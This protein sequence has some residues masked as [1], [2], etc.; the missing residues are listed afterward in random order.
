MNKK[1]MTAILVTTLVMLVGTSTLFAKGAKELAPESYLGQIES[2]EVMEGGFNYELLVKNADGNTVLFRTDDQTVA[3]LPLASL[4]KGDYV[5]ILFNGIMTR[6]IPPQ[7]TADSV[8]WISA[9]VNTGIIDLKAPVRKAATTTIVAEKTTP[10]A[11]PAPAA[12]PTVEP[13]KPVA[14]T[15]PATSTAKPVAT[16]TFETP[17][18]ASSATEKPA[19]GIT[20][21]TVAK[22]E[23]AT[24]PAKKPAVTAPVP[25]TSPAVKPEATVPAT[26]APATKPAVT[27]PATPAPAT[28]PEADKQTNSSKPVQ[29]AENTF[30][31]RGTVIE[32]SEA[33]NKGNIAILVQALLPGIGY[34][35]PEIKFILG[36]G[37]TGDISAAKVGDYVEVTYGPAMTMS[38]PPQTS[39]LSIKVLPNPSIVTA[40]V[41]YLGKMF[42]GKDFKTGS[43]LV[44]NPATEQEEIYLFDDGSV[45]NL[46]I[47]D[48][49]IGSHISL[50]HRGTMTRSYPAQGFA[51]CI[52]Y[53]YGE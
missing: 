48:L 13:G 8:R 31:Y 7:A 28:K 29:I 49:P 19:A 38:L 12:K 3:T 24:E 2:I 26:P 17:S 47:F 45:I 41:I 37:T 1:R 25:A 6:S 53:T 40:N 21:P 33:D 42:D 16:V 18:A 50:Y 35:E 4:R 51:Y 30:L 11:A 22:P 46:N 39:A 5:E 32:R 20:A 9:L 43:V 44:L 14:A 15:Q 23:A 52:D 10:A 27:T 36:S 34:G